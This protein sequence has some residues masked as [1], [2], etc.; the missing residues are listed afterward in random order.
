MR[1][2]VNSVEE[3]GGGMIIRFSDS[4][5]NHVWGE[6]SPGDDSYYNIPNGGM[7][8]GVMDGSFHTLRLTMDGAILTAYMDG[9]PVA[10]GTGGY[11]LVDLPTANGWNLGDGTGGADADWDIDYI[12]WTDAGAFAPP[13]STNT[14]S[15]TTWEGHY[16]ADDF[17]DVESGINFDTGGGTVSG[18]L[19]N[20]DTLG[21]DG[22]LLW[23]GAANSL[24]PT[25]SFTDGAS[26]E[27]RFRV[28]SYDVDGGAMLFRVSD[29]AGSMIYGE[30]SPEGGGFYT[31]TDGLIAPVSGMVGGSFHTLRL[32]M[33]GSIL[34]AYLDDNPVEVGTGTI[35]LTGDNNVILFGDGTGAND[36]DWDIDYIRWTNDGAFVPTPEPVCPKYDYNKDG[37]INLGDFGYLAQYWLV[38]DPPLNYNLQGD[39]ILNVSDLSAFLWHWLETTPCNT[40]EDITT[41]AGLSGLLGGGDQN[42]DARPVALGD[43]NNDGWVDIYTGWQLWQNDGDSINPHFSIFTNI[44]GF[45]DGL[46]GDYDNDGFLDLFTWNPWGVGGL[47]HNVN[48]QSFVDVTSSY[49]PAMPMD[50]SQ[51]AVWADYNG[52]G[53]LDMYVTGWESGGDQPDCVLLSNAGT[54]FS[55]HWTQSPIYNAR[56]VTACDFDQDFDIDTY[57][58]N[59]RLQPNI[60]WRNNGSASFNNNIAGTHNVLATSLV[61]AGGHSIG[62][63]WGDFDNDGLFDIFAGNF[64]HNWSGGQPESRFLRNRGATFDYAFDDLG[65]CGVWWQESYASPALGDYDNDGYLDLFFT[66]AYDNND[67]SVLFRNNGDWTF[68]DVTAEVGLSDLPF[69]VQAAWA[70][71]NH[72]GY[73]DLVT[74]GRLLLNS[75]GYNHWLRVHL[76]STNPTV[77]AAA[78]GTQ[79]RIT[80]ISGKTLTRQVE[81]ATGESNQNDLTLHFGLGTHGDQVDLEIRWPDGTIQNVSTPVDRLVEIVISAP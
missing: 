20:L 48:G 27:I 42:Q 70:D 36:A 15:S 40:F 66:T 67:A 68:T 1:F 58:S 55:L 5:G 17:P 22:Y 59:Y 79:V 50:R 72:D 2:R 80:N 62:A 41:Q 6:I 19:L 10:T 65:Q 69:T 64:A 78:I 46:W 75:G 52:D 16:E 35:A 8:S 9:N 13:L 34:N 30:F 63:A 23:G 14:G 39:N 45:T 38:A 32:T 60:L 11:T 54:S 21:T 18:G 25:L 61:W 51:A 28:N 47:Y 26:M 4:A 43:F 57:V 37:I 3:D 77:N 12:R 49:L 7:A 71:V 33:S 74:S 29:T 31:V 76:T 73:L 24:S 44:P 81:G 56:G 53:Y